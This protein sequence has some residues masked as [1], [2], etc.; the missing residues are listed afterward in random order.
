MKLNDYVDIIW[1]DEAADKYGHLAPDGYFEV[2]APQGIKAWER[3]Y[4]TEIGQGKTLALELALSTLDH[5][6]IF[7]DRECFQ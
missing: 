5:D 6:R 1:S 3:K 4:I 2:I 7:K